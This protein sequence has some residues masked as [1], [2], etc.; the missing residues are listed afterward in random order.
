MKNVEWGAATYLASSIYGKD[1]QK[2]LATSSKSIKYYF[3]G[4]GA[5]NMAIY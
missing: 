2:P 5:E 1:S 3:T 4:G